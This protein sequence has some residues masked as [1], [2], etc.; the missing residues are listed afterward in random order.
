MAT[1]VDFLVTI[2]CVEGLHA[3]YLLATVLGNTAGGI[4]NFYLGRHFVFH[5]AG[6]GHPAQAGRYVLVWAGSMLLNAAGVFLFTH[7][8]GVNYLY[9]KIVVSLVVGLGFNYLL[10]RY[11]VFR[12]S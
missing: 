3:W 5:A 9:S 11:F 12:K 6:P 4:T 1:V 7:A 10:Q 8:L 2:G